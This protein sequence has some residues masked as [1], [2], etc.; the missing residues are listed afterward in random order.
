MSPLV[1]PFFHSA[2]GTWSYVVADASGMAAIV[3]PV[4]DYEPRAARTA[5]LFADAILAHVHDRKLRVA[6]I[7]ETHAHA[8]HLSA[9]DYLRRETAAPLAIGRGIVQV[10]K[11]FKP[12]FGLGD[13]FRADGHDFDRLLDDGDSLEIGALECR[14]LATPGHTPDGL[15]YVTGD[16]AFV[17][18]TLF[19]PDVGSA[20]CDFPGG[21]AA[22]EWASIQRILALP[23]DTRLFLAH[24]YPPRG[25]EPVAQISV[26]DQ[27]ARNIHVAGKDQASF[28][29]LREARDP[30]L[31]PPTLL[32]PALQV[33]L[34][35]GR[36]PEPEAD[37]ARYLRIPLD[38]L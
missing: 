11:H 10:Q 32:L 35:G 38:R 33:N 27:R 23:D 4:L 30:T 36:L 5:T 2:T 26:A 9:G 8:D 31:G 18:D 24:D 28:V 15:T 3:D 19:A 1:T 29:A 21:D 37:G 34:R 12:V 16:A 25:R 22:V 20:R 17:G 13:E 14:V 6:W 7:L